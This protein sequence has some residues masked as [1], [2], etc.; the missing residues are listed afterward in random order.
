MT[1]MHPDATDAAAWPLPLRAL[2]R[3][4]TVLSGGA[5]LL[6]RAGRVALHTDDDG[7]GVGSRSPPLHG[8]A[9]RAFTVVGDAAWGV[10]AMAQRRTFDVAAAAA[11]PVQAAGAVLLRLAGKAAQRA[12]VATPLRELAQGGRE[13]RRYNEGEAARAA[14]GAV[15]RIVAAASAQMDVDQVVARVD[16]DAV[17]ARLDVVEIVDRVLDDVDLSRIVRE[18]S[19]TMTA[20][21]VGTVRVQ[22]RRADQALG[23]FVDRVLRRDAA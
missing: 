19:T 16:L 3:A 7:D 20:E 10:G 1:P 5:G 18:S 4:G 22:S 21:T 17:I 9:G 2:D 11:L 13:V 8:A 6:L 23:R 14:R 12:G 15:R